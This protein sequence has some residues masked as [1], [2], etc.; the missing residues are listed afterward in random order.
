MI[1]KIDFPSE[2]IKTL[3]ERS[4]I[5]TTRVSREYNRYSLGDIVQT[6]WGKTYVVNKIEKING[7]KNHPFYHELTPKQIQLI[8]KYKKIDVLTLKKQ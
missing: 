4:C 7:I 3:K 1:K 2:E 6:P 5:I 8:S